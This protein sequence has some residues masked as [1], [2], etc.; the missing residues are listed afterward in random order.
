M[1]ASTDSSVLS[2]AYAMTKTS[3]L[4]RCGSRAELLGIGLGAPSSRAGARVLQHDVAESDV[5]RAHGQSNRVE[6]LGRQ[7]AVRSGRDCE[8]SRD[9]IFFSDE[10]EPMRPVNDLD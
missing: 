4:E 9:E 10:F 7:D 3:S 6:P 5:D 1:R 8:A 2:A